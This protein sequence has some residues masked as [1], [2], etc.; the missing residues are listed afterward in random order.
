MTFVKTMAVIA[1]VCHVLLYTA[2]FAFVYQ[3]SQI[4]PTLRGQYKKLKHG[5]FAWLYPRHVRGLGAWLKPNGILYF[6][7]E[8]SF[9][10]KADA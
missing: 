3:M 9:E 1:T 2:I 10:Q 6:L 4:F 7:G 5:T 8:S